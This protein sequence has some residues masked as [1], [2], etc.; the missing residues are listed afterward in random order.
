MV[1]G[2]GL[3]PRMSIQESQN[4]IDPFAPKRTQAATGSLA[5]FFFG[6]AKQ[7]N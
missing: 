4:L 5:S 1:E 2:L 3:D 7:T 6:G